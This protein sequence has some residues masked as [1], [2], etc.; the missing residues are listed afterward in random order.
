MSLIEMKV[1]MEGPRSGQ[2]VN[3]TVSRGILIDEEVGTHATEIGNLEILGINTNPDGLDQ[4]MVVTND[5][6]GKE[7]RIPIDPLTG[8]ARHPIL[9]SGFSLELVVPSGNQ[10]DSL[11]SRLVIAADLMQRQPA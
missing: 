2:V 3:Q 5:S 9:R 4:H 11:P 8:V 7:V 6:I 10:L 1:I